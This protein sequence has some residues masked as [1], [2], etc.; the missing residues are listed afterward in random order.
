M[1]NPVNDGWIKRWPLRL[2]LRRLGL[3]LIAVVLFSGMTACGTAV[4]G[5]K[6][7]AK[8]HHS[9]EPA[10]PSNSVAW[11]MALSVVQGPPHAVLLTT[12]QIWNATGYDAADSDMMTANQNPATGAVLPYMP[13]PITLNLPSN[14]QILRIVTSVTTPQSLQNDMA[15]PD[16]GTVVLRLFYHGVLAVTVYGSNSGD[17]TSPGPPPVEGLVFY[18]SNTN[19]HFTVLESAPGQ[20]IIWGPAAVSYKG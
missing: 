6:S 14:W 13:V 17:N 2:A 8:A 5:T 4:S 1:E 18:L 19:R 11:T 16:V 15:P 9:N 20:Q 7:L 10:A 3:V 12:T